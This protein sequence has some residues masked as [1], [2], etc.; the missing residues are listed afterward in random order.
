MPN[1]NSNNNNNNNANTIHHTH[2]I[3][4][5]LIHKFDVFGSIM[6]VL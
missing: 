4:K 3:N 5:L 2:I 6:V 1:A